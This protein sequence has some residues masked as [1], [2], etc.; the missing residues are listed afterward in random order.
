MLNLV[1]F[2]FVLT[3]VVL[4][5]QK[6]TGIPGSV[7]LLLSVFALNA[8]GMEVLDISSSGFDQLL[9]VLLP[10]LIAVDVLALKLKDLMTHG[11]SLFY[12]AVVAVSL[13]VLAGVLLNTFILPEYQLTMPALVALFCMCMA[14]DP[15]AV[16]AVFSNFKIPHTLKV[17]AEG[18]SLF[19]DAT[20][21]IIFGIAVTFLGTGTVSVIE[22]GEHAVMVVV[23]AILIGL[24]AG[25]VGLYALSLSRDPMVETAIMLAIVF[26]AFAAA[27]H[28]HWSGILA[29]IV[30]ALTANHVI[31]K[32]VEDDD[33]IIEASESG[34]GGSL[35]LV[36]RFEDAVVDK[37]NHGHILQ[38][39]RYTAVLATTVLFLSMAELI[40]FGLLVTYWKEIAA[41]FVSTTLIRALMML[42]FSVVSNRLGFMQ[43]IPSHWWLILSLAGVK[44]A[45]S[46]LM[47]H[48]IPSDFENLALFEAVVVGHI[49][50]S[51]FIYPFAMMAVMKVFGER[52]N[53]EYTADPAHH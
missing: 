31:T 35:S 19:N 37:V 17:L 20:A 48:M 11:A 34:Q 3:A 30:A 42:K 6:K 9:F 10:V 21:L 7:S 49:L 25:L 16:S 51:T 8:L 22:L 33:K 52:F 18:E 24:A 43:N 50:L 44:G 26:G 36:R 29:I 41:V 46:L 28:F 14:T 40:E 15:I 12:S 53:A 2:V 23:G 45:L 39:I 4:V 1:L 47:L 5:V 32:R 38:N 13:S 27:E